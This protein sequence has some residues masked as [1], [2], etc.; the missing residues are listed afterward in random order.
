MTL[1]AE[2]AGLAG[3]EV[4]WILEAEVVVML[5]MLCPDVFMNVIYTRVQYVSV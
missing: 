5:S 3:D 2:T 1:C 4:E